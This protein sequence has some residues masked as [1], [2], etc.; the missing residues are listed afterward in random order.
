MFV[1]GR[2]QQQLLAAVLAIRC[3]DL[4]LSFGW[5]SLFAQREVRKSS[6]YREAREASQR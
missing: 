2:Q 5:L 3:I 6:G 1:I 4:I